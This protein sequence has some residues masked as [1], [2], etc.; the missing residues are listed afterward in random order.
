[1]WKPAQ[2][3]RFLLGLAFLIFGLNGFYS[4]I[5]VPD[6]NLFMQV[7]VSSGYIYFIKAVEVAAGS[8]LLA[9]RAVVLALVLLGADIAN[10]VAYH[11]LLDHRNWLIVPIIVGLYVV[12]LWERR[13][14]LKFLLRWKD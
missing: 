6:F 13:L 9:N 12:V 11:I 1:M 10:I 3:A 4:F 14:Q 5:P 2:V 7:L 8:L